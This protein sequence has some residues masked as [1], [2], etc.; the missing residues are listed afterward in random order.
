M[1]RET[2]PYN[3][4]SEMPWAQIKVRDPIIMGEKGNEHWGEA[5]VSTTQRVSSI[6]QCRKLLPRGC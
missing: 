2:E 5:A 6:L 1:Q 4:Y 3:L